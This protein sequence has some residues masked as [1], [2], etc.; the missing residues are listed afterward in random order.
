MN[1]LCKWYSAFL[2]SLDVKLLGDELAYIS[3]NEEVVRELEISISGK[4][5]PVTLPTKEAF[6]NLDWS[7]IVAYHPGSENLCGGQSE[8]LN[9]TLGLVSAKL[10]DTLVSN[11]VAL[12]QLSG[13]TK[14]VNKLPAGVVKLLG[15]LPPMSEGVKNSVAEVLKACTG[16]S[17]KKPLFKIVLTRG[18]EIDGE[19]M[20][21][22][23]TLNLVGIKDTSICGVAL[24][25]DAHMVICAL[26]KLCLPE[27]L[28]YGSNSVSCPY[29]T[30]LVTLYH[31]I[32]EHLNGITEQLGKRSVAP[33]INLEWWEGL[34]NLPKLVKTYLNGKSLR[35]NQGPNLKKDEVNASEEAPAP[36]PLTPPPAYLNY[37]PSVPATTQQSSPQQVQ[38]PTAT[39]QAAALRAALNAKHGVYGNASTGTYDPRFHN[40]Q[41]VQQYSNP[42]PQNNYGYPSQVPTA[43]VPPWA[44]TVNEG[45]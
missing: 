39:A 41:P 11:M 21:R 17:G 27:K 42:I 6:A 45:Y 30:S 38:P 23:A 5:Y 15:K 1:D 18:G 20:S 36:A 19:S 26:I 4:K 25:K 28:Q 9:L 33:L 29:F 40:P 24:N 3:P 44:Q 35:G 37:Q 13:N 10:F 22:I 16:I 31:G 7:K 14:E 34:H 43:V 12:A 8:I 32:S 2:R